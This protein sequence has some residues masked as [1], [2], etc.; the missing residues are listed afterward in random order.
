MTL[1][2]RR[3]LAAQN[4][5]TGRESNDLTPRLPDD[6]PNETTRNPQNRAPQYPKTTDKRI[7]RRIMRMLES[8][9]VVQEVDRFHRNH[10]GQK[11]RISTKALL[12]G[13][14][15]AAYET[16]R[17]LRSDICSYLNGLEHRLGVELGL[18]TWDNREPVTYTMSQKQSKR[19]E[20]AIF[21]ARYSSNDQ[22]RSIDW[23]MDALFSDTIPNQAKA[24]ITTGS[25]DST[26]IRGWAVPRDYRVEE[27]V[28][29][30]QEPED[31]GEIGTLN[32]RDRLIRSAD[33]DAL[34]GH[35]TATNKT[36][37]GGFTGYYGHIII[38]TRGATWNGNPKN[39]TLGPLPPKYVPHGRA[40]PANNDN[41]L[42]GLHA[43]LVALENFP[44]LTEIIA[45][46]G[47][48]IYGKAFV[49]PL[50]RMGINVVMDY[51]EG[52]Q[53]KIKTVTIGPEGE[54]QILLL[55]CGTFLVEWTPERFWIPPIHLTGEGTSQ[56]VRRPGQIPVDTHRQTRQERCYPIQMPT[57]RRQSQNQRQNPHLQ[58]KIPTQSTLRRH[59]RPRILLPRH[60][61]H[62][63][64]RT[65]HLPAHPLRD[66][67]L[68]KELR[69]TP[70]NREPQQPRQKRRRPRRRL[71]PGTRTSRPQLRTPRSAN[72]SQPT[73]TQQLRP[74]RR[75]T[76]RTAT[77]PHHQPRNHTRYR[78]RA[79]NP[80]PTPIT[81]PGTQ[82]RQPHP[83]VGFS[84]PRKP[85]PG[86]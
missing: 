1:K 32:L 52:H 30:E 23:F 28:R 78:Q 10:P 51:T 22:P 29:K 65:R 11:S 74:R 15:L 72:R 79:Q 26:P 3:Q 59:H 41:A 71:V 45:D 35:S 60:R 62:S 37:A 2:Q 12:L 77:H 58:Q 83:A 36:S 7:V 38:P 70:A 76:Q 50:H 5:Q 47:Y 55:H 43:A 39:L 48:T 20:T 34:G 9:T 73:P 56:V 84:A 21:E 25:L 67:R 69:P 14:V 17:Y 18:W 66:S 57:M 6:F 49:R 64:R 68:E 81:H 24:T 53:K 54:E 16:G 61:H 82:H 8:T 33:P 86:T 42:N 19:I 46:R 4:G 63:R 27:E 13:M 85:K 80:R 31:T 75:T 40:I 44:N